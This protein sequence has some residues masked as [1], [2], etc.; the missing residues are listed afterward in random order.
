MDGGS[1]DFAS[2]ALWGPYLGA[3]VSGP[4]WGPCGTQ[5]PFAAELFSWM[6]GHYLWTG[7]LETSVH[8]CVSRGV[9]PSWL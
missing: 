2:C 3:K 4:F 8:V 1:G 7:Y 5:R 9:W 6:L